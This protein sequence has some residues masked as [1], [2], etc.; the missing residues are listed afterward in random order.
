[1][2]RPG[3]EISRFAGFSC[4]AIALIAQAQTYDVVIRGGRVIDPNRSWTRFAI[5]AWRTAKYCAVSTSPLNGRT[6]IDAG[7]LVVAPGFIDLHS[8]GQD[9]ENYRYKAMDGVTTAL[10]AGD[11]RS[12]R[13]GRLVSRARRRGPGELWRQHGPSGGAVWPSC[14]EPPALLPRADAAYRTATGEEITDM[15]RR[16]ETGLKKGGIASS[17]SATRPGHRAGR[18]WKCLRG[19]RFRRALLSSMYAAQAGRTWRRSRR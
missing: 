10:V 17:E 19:A 1:M 6:V 16:L 3:F 4:L 2:M 15:R 7:G 11:R 8:H 18:Y 14:M 5:S 9:A 13:C 12:G